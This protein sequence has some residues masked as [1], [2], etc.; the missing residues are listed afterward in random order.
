MCL[1]LSQKS[2]QICLLRWPSSF[3]LLFFLRR[4]LS[5]FRDTNVI[6]PHHLTPNVLQCMVGGYKY[7]FLIAEENHL[8]RRTQGKVEKNQRHDQ[9]CWPFHLREMQ[10]W[11]RQCPAPRPLGKA[12][13]PSIPSP[14]SA[15]FSNS[16]ERGSTSAVQYAGQKFRHAGTN[17]FHLE[18]SFS[19]YC[20]RIKSKLDPVSKRRSLLLYCQ[21]F[22]FSKMYSFKNFKW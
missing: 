22:L 14:L 7:S 6:F 19:F 21:G 18:I 1:R 3:A 8:H 17:L 9:N 11:S 15:S 20:C 10:S 5:I 12:Y 16:S 13:S 4:Y 2:F